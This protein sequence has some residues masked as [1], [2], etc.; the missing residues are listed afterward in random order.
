MSCAYTPI[1]EDA[2]L[3]ALSEFDV[4]AAAPDP[5][6]THV[7][8]LAAQLLDAPTAF[9]SF[10]ERD[11]QVFHA[12]L[13]LDLNETD[14]DVAFCS[15]TILQDDVLVVL[16]ATHDPRFRDN[17]LVTGAPFV[18]FYAGA[19]LR[20]EDGHT[21]G[22]LCLA[23]PEPRTAFT[24]RDQRV[25]TSLA[26]L[27]LDRLE[28]RRSTIAQRATQSRFEHIAGTSPD[29]IICADASGRI[30]FWNDAAER[31]F[32][33]VAEEVLGRSIDLIVPERMLSGHEGSLRQ[34]AD[35]APGSLI[36]RT[37][38]LF[39]RHRQ[40]GEFPIELSLSMWR[41][42]DASAF[43]AIVRDVSDRHAV[44]RQLFRLAHHDV[45]TGLLNRSVL[46]GQLTA[47]LAQA[48]PTAV[49]MLDLDGF[50]DVNDG[51]GHAVGDA[52]LRQTAERVKACVGSDAVAARLGGDEFA[53]IFPDVG[54]PLI[55]IVTAE[56]ILA[57]MSEPFPVGGQLLRLSASVGVA[58]SPAH[59]DEAEDLLI[60]ADAALYQAKAD[61]RGRYRLFTPN[62]REAAQRERI[63]RDGLRNAVER[64]EFE[65][66]Y[67]PQVR[68]SDGALLGAE[69]LIRWRH[70]D[71]GL[72][73]PAAFL[74]TLETG[75]HA[76]V[77]GDWVLRTACAQ[78][79]VW[80]RNGVPDFRIGVNLFGAQFARGDLTETVSRA[81]IETGLPGANLELEIT[82]NIILRHD[83]VLVGALRDLRRLSVGVAFDDYG[84]GYASL[85]LLKRFPLTRLKIDRSFVQNLC[86]DPQDAAIVRAILKLSRSFGLEVIAEGVETEEQRRRLIA[87]G[88]ET[89]QGYLFGRPMPAAEFAE[90]FGLVGDRSAEPVTTS[91][92][93]SG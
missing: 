18:R 83:E 25:L 44:E 85:S 20:T 6:L 70:P 88:C 19:P 37:V 92:R 51:H 76:A 24:D 46:H 32:G 52:V 65:L 3:R 61:G 41:E 42:G 62:L 13:G 53:V 2:R 35:G 74:T 64:G 66:H 7:V 50:K 1:D 69:A 73:G 59:S 12:K 43:G 87:K 10:V 33:H 78:A 58:L 54:D 81:L 60:C 16:D 56:A 31:I 39:G 47:S 4:V 21:I 71:H 23:G 75:Q 91:Q 22:T 38:E 93:R 77:V 72:I 34:L 84:T 36:G 27:V 30:T 68:L 14:R 89:A 90:R 28:L 26:R 29:G 63:C 48:L 80:R 17:P 86:E 15:R 55:A 57:A 49:L 11:R 82:E 45:L 40:G 79:E 9:V 5:A 8:E 67:Q